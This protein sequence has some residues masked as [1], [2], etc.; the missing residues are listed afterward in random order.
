M[1][2]ITK[3]KCWNQL[4]SLGFTP[5]RFVFN[6]KV[7]CIGASNG[8]I[9]IEPKNFSYSKDCYHISGHANKPITRE[10]YRYNNIG[11]KEKFYD[12]DTFINDFFTAKEIMHTIN[13]MNN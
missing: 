1:K 9:T 10:L 2:N 6:G 3:L 5:I 4:E 7:Q 12:T 8:N 11:Q 13:K